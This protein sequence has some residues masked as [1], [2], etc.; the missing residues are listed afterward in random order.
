MLFSTDVAAMGVHF[1]GL[2]IGVSLGAYFFGNTLKMSWNLSVQAYQTLCGNCS[3]SVVALE[4]VLERTPFSSQL[5]QR[6]IR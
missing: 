3:R 5:H 2:C 6:S 4:E 1:P